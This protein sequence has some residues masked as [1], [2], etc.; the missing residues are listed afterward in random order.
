[1]NCEVCKTTYTVSQH[2]ECMETFIDYPD[3]Q[4]VTD[5]INRKREVF[6]YL[7]RVIKSQILRPERFTPIPSWFAKTPTTPATLGAPLDNQSRYLDLEGFKSAAAMINSAVLCT[8]NFANDRE[9]LMYVGESSYMLLRFMVL[10]NPL[11]LEHVSIGGWEQFKVTWDETTEQKFERSGQKP[12]Y[13]YHGSPLS[14]WQSIMI[15]G[16]K[17]TSGTAWMSTGAAYG[18]GIYASDTLTISY[19]YSCGQASVVI[20]VYEIY[21]PQ[22]YLKATGYFVVPT[23]DLML[24]RYL[25]YIPTSN[26]G[27]IVALDQQLKQQWDTKGTNKAAAIVSKQK[28]IEVR[29]S[30]EIT[31]LQSNAADVTRVSASEIKVVMKGCTHN[32]VFPFMFPFSAPIISGSAPMDHSWSPK[33]TVLD[34]LI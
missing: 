5:L 32:I 19:S 27:K 6:A 22:K 28:K 8:K 20:G 33:S 29:I 21:E 14:N 34:L 10:R 24:L 1:M 30:R 15:N 9:L 25:I 23:E 18:N 12:E 31:L 3:N 16:L 11:K 13:L 4:V 2:F 7:V 26:A 17:V